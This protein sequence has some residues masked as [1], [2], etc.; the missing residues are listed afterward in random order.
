MDYKIVE[1]N[2]NNLLDIF[3]TEK[4]KMGNDILEMSD[5]F[6]VFIKKL[7]A[8]IPLNSSWKL[9]PNVNVGGLIGEI[10]SA[11]KSGI[12]ITKNKVLVADQSH[13][14][15]TILNGLESG[16]YHI[17]ESKEVEG[18]FRPAIL[19]E[20]GKLVKF[21]TLKKAYD[22]S[23]VLS[24]IAIMSIQKSLRNISI[25]IKNMEQDLNRL[26]DF[27]RRTQFSD[28]FIN[29]RSEIKL[30][31]NASANEQKD[32]LKDADKYL[33]EGLNALYSDFNAHIEELSQKSVW[34]VSIDKINTLL[35]YITEDMQMISRFV[36]LRVYLLNYRGKIADATQVLEEYQY[37]LND[38]KTKKIGGF[39][40]FEHIHSYYPYS[41]RNMDYWLKTPQQ[42]IEA[43]N[44]YKQILL[45]QNDREIIYIDVEDT[46]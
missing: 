33:M 46:Q 25:Q 20:D 45:D 40:A 21:F 6:G 34:N 9:V 19:D 8:K 11:I 16:I 23:S 42:M 15:Q 38:W 32:H 36:G 4:D 22:P 44:S 24:D 1:S 43:I 30:A 41:K 10:S 18:N 26:M 27:K 29:A 14:S 17:G 31:A 3:I 28:R 35:S 12:D 5:F 7:D 39:T 37:N 13:F 2:K